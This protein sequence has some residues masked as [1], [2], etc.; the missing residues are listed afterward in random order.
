MPLFK[1]LTFRVNQIEH[2]AF[3]NDAEVLANRFVQPTGDPC[4]HEHGHHAHQGHNESQNE[5]DSESLLSMFDLSGYS[6][7]F[8][9][10][11]KHSFAFDNLSEGLQEDGSPGHYRYASAALALTGC[12]FIF[13]AVCYLLAA[14]ARACMKGMSK[15][16]TQEN[17]LAQ[18]TEE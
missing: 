14:S 9:E 6:N 18:F 5:A 8:A 4:D 1:T 3:H 7:Y 11:I 12:V 13:S 2:L 10:S 17:S 15:T 16:K